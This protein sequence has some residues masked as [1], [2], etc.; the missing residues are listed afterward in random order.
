[1]NNLLKLSIL[2]FTLS[3]SCGNPC[4]TCPKNGIPTILIFNLASETPIEATNSSCRFSNYCI[5]KDNLTH[6]NLN[7]NLCRFG[8]GEYNY[9]FCS[10][11]NAI[12]KCKLNDENLAIKKVYYNNVTKA[13]AINDCNSNIKGNWLDI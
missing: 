5:E 8:K 1:M 6:D 7:K 2:I 13:T 11:L 3:L 9:N 4:G 10:N 12:G